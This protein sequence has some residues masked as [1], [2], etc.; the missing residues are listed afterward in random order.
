[1]Q[2]SAYIQEDEVIQSDGVDRE[3]TTLTKYQHYWIKTGDA[4]YLTKKFRGA[5]IAG[6]VMHSVSNV[7]RQEIFKFDWR[8]ELQC[9]LR[10][11][12]VIR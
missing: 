3:D 4:L 7:I 9:Q 6:L 5:C 11:V 1:M 2:I 12:P 10:I 8:I